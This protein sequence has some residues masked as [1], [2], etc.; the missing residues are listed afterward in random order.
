MNLG[1]VY[2]SPYLDSEID[3][4]ERERKKTYEQNTV[5]NLNSLAVHVN[6]MHSDT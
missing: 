1:L 3:N 6:L 5:V 2:S 4:T